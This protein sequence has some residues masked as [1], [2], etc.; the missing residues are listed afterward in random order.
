MNWINYICCGH[1]WPLFIFMNQIRWCKHIITM[2][3]LMSLEH[4]VY[5]INSCIHFPAEIRIISS[6]KP[7]YQ[8]QSN[9]DYFSFYL[10]GISYTIPLSHL[11]PAKAWPFSDCFLVTV[12]EAIWQPRTVYWIDP[13]Y[14]GYP[15]EAML[16]AFLEVWHHVDCS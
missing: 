10:V 13:G 15:L 7:M 3:K 8:I 5:Q 14:W 4:F 1:L 11:F 16:E 6:T 12:T 2:A 9:C